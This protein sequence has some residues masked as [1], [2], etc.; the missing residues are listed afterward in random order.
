MDHVASDTLPAS[1]CL[2]AQRGTALL[3]TP[4]DVAFD[5][6]TRLASS[7]LQVPVALIGLVRENRRFIHGCIGMPE[8]WAS[9]RERPL[10]DSPFLDAL[11]S[12][13]PLLIED[14]R[15]HPLVRDHVAVRDLGAIACAGIPLLTSQGYALGSFCVIDSQPRRWTEGEIGM[16]RDLA[17][18]AM[19]E[20][21]LR[22]EMEGR[23]R[24]E[25]AL[26][27][28]EQS[29]RRTF[30]GT[31][32]PMWIFDP[33]T[34]AFLDVNEAAVRHYGYAREEFFAERAASAIDNA[35]LY[36]RS[37][38][39]VHAR[40]EILAIVSELR[41][42]LNATRA[43]LDLLLEG[44][45]PEA[46]HPQD[47][48]QLESIQGST[49]QMAR[50][51]HDLE[52]IT[53]IESGHLRIYPARLEPGPLVAMAVKIFRPLAEAASLRLECDVPSDLPGERERVSTSRSEW[54]RTREKPR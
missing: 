29:I 40:D 12:G 28:S 13:E 14:A 7:A 51:V 26:H 33:E 15:E 43:V 35:R 30:E 37:Q 21:E 53:R 25:H 49:A 19:T 4:L 11:A 20:A 5:R 24:A 31:P 52:D 32:L 47:R 34:L 6:L 45:S 39:A 27:R 42:P 54:K 2:D 9:L 50:L 3:D 38:Q 10:S 41:G 44:R 17:A 46:W 22:M 36:H 16:L 23:R 48:K 18:T 1:A 8:P